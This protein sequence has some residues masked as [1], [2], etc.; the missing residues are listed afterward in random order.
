MKARILL[1]SDSCNTR[2][3][4]EAPC[5][6][7][8]QVGDKST[9]R[10]MSLPASLN[11]LLICEK[12]SGVSRARGGWPGGSCGSSCP[13]SEEIGC[14]VRQHLGKYN[15]NGHKDGRS[16]QEKVAEKARPPLALLCQPSLIKPV[17]DEQ[18]SSAQKV[19]SH[20]SQH[21]GGTGKSGGERER[22]NW[23]TA[24]RCG[25]HAPDR[26]KAGDCSTAIACLARVHGTVGGSFHSFTAI[27]VYLH[28]TASGRVK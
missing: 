24:T 6:Q 4:A 16:T 3:T 23:Q 10:R 25:D 28:Q 9:S 8:G 17:S 14:G 27:C 11:A 12:F 22:Q 7:T 2:S 13:P 19:G 5:R 26:R 18:D 1:A 21:C 15:R 20:Y